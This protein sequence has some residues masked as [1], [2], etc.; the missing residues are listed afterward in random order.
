MIVISSYYLRRCA[1]NLVDD[2][3]Q[4]GQPTARFTRTIVHVKREGWYYSSEE[5]P[6]NNLLQQARHRRVC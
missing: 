6:P 2:L 1:A 5:D 4:G 3:E